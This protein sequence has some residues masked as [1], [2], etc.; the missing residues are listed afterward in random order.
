[1]V[2]ILL[3]FLVAFPSMNPLFFLTLPDSPEMT[4]ALIPH[5]FLKQSSR[6]FEALKLLRR[7][8]ENFC[9]FF[10]LFLQHRSG[11]GTGLFTRRQIQLL[12]CMLISR[13]LAHMSHPSGS[14]ST[15]KA[16]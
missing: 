9:N 12:T 11:N 2:P 16:I 10:S 3:E 14:V 13:A 1:M 4:F 15:T 7:I 8:F 6:P 5:L